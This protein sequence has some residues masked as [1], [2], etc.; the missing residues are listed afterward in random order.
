MARKGEDTSVLADPQMMGLYN[1]T[2]FQR[3]VLI[4]VHCTASSE[5]ERPSL[6]EL[7]YG[8]QQ[9]QALA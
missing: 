7:L 2:S 5:R 8:L 1:S 9:E 3:V 6:D 4:A